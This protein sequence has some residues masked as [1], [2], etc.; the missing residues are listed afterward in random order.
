M[1]ENIRMDSHKLI[2]HPE[3]V[4]R[5]LNGENIYPIEI[6]ISLSGACNHRCVFCALEHLGYEPNFLD[7]DVILRNVEWM[8]RKGL[9]S[10]VCAGEGSHC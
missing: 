6:E 7:K 1:A 3:T 8:S 9:K 10:V 2:Y 5:W 4:G